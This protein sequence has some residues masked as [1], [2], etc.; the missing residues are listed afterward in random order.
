MWLLADLCTGAVVTS[1]CR[2]REGHVTAW[3]W[4]LLTWSCHDLGTQCSGNGRSLD[5]IWPIFNTIPLYCDLCLNFW[6]FQVEISMCTAR[7]KSVVKLL[8]ITQ[9]GWQLDIYYFEARVLAVL[10]AN[11]NNTRDCCTCDECCSSVLITF[12]SLLQ[13]RNLRRQYGGL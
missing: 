5:H 12:S 7:S 3:P 9:S 6:T 13:L 1:Q 2:S 11:N 10:A 8:I 4:C